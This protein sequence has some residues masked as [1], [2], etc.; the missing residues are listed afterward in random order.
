MT[1]DS[2]KDPE[3]GEIEHRSSLHAL[4]QQCNDFKN[5]LSALQL[6][7]QELGVVVDTTPKYHAK[8][9]GE[10]IE[11][12]WGYSK[13]NLLFNVLSHTATSHAVLLQAPFGTATQTHTNDVHKSHI[14]SSSW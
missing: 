5:E 1:L 4:L 7:A 10:G 14:P 11:Y 8:L 3:T 9:A 6:L 2:H 12:S 13:L